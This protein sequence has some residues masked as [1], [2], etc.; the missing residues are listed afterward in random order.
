[1]GEGGLLGSAG[2]LPGNGDKGEVVIET[3]DCCG[4][5][6][7]RLA[8]VVGVVRDGTPPPGGG[9]LGEATKKRSTHISKLKHLSFTQ[10]ETF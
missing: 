5:C 1:M 9:K 3:G 4:I 8:G 10:R 6:A 7:V 2:G